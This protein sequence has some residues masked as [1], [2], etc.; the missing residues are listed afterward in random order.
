MSTLDADSLYSLL[1]AFVRLRDQTQGGGALQALMQVIAGQAQVISDGLDQLYDDQFIET[2]APWVVPYIGDLIGFT[3]LQPLGPGQ[4]AATRAEVADTIG[5]R[6][7]KGTL[8]MLEQLCFDVTGWP[9]MAVEY[10]TRL[11]TAQYVRNHIR[12][13]NAIVD[14]RSPMTATDVGSAF[15]VVPHTVDVRRIDGGRG[16]HNIMNVG[17]FV[18]RLQAYTNSGHP[19]RQ[20]AANQFTFDPFGGDVPLV[21]P[22]VPVPSEFSLDARDN[23]PFYLARYPLFADVTP[24]ATSP[25]AAVSVNGVAVPGAAVGWCDLSA[26]APPTAP[27]I[28]VAVDP[29]LGRLVFATPPLSTDVVA[30]DYSYAFSGDYGGGDYQRAVSSDDATAEGSLPSPTVTT[31]AA[32]DLPA[33]HDQ[34]VEISDSGIVEGDLTL[35]PDAH[36]LVVRAADWQRPVLTG[37]LTI[38]G[39]GGASVTLR[40]LAI[41]GSLSINGA[42]PLTVRLE[43]CTVRGTVD[44]SAAGLIGTLVVDHSL[45]GPLETNDGVDVTITD[46]AVDAGSDTAAALSGGTAGGSLM[47]AGSLTVARST[48]LGTVSARTIPLFENSVVTGPVV[49][50]ERQAGCFR[51][52]F[53]PVTGS[54]T[55]VRFRCQPDLEINT[56]VAA[57][58]AANPAFDATAAAALTAQ[59]TAWLLPAFTSRSWGQ[60]GYLQL[61][62]AAP[63]QIRFGAQDGD[64]M[65]VF[66]GLFSARREANL[67]YRVREYLRLGLEAGIIHAT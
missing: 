27:G 36:L 64:E 17:L 12:P 9:C 50:T 54:Q 5:Y 38:T 13:G 1:P 44:W 2:C 56:E 6:R 24:Y 63:D 67:A 48:V 26:W 22:A 41:G 55:P 14:V 51:Y 7:R 62:D 4:P 65:G 35:A 60:P 25:P 11:A 31:F 53:V 37:N 52:S 49:S 61:A 34:V 16:R 10:F 57:A 20:V 21:N 46:S 15:D 18:W 58:R 39:V 40:G 32:A 19:A 45:C 43:H 30:V 8:A 59:V 42:G 23:L 47:A 29:V 28:D 3:P 66:Y 33:A